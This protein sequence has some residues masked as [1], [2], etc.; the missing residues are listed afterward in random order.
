MTLVPAS[1]TQDP[2]QQQ[3]HHHP[4]VQLQ[5]HAQA[6]DLVSQPG[7][8]ESTAPSWEGV[9]ARGGGGESSASSATP[10]VT[11]GRGLSG[12]GGGGVI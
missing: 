8:P 11:P 3:H 6:A 5:P 7:A 12:A 10:E 1:P 2:E 4:G 9:G